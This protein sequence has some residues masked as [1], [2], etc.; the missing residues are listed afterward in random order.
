MDGAQ[1]QVNIWK[2]RMQCLQAAVTYGAN[3][4]VEDLLQL[5]DLFYAWAIYD[6][7]GMSEAKKRLFHE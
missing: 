7:T 6:K 1:A 2:I 4:S 5:A 3:Y